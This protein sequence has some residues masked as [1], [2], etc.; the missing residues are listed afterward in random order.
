M[1][2]KLSLCNCSYSFKNFRDVSD[3]VSSLSRLW[4]EM[5]VFFQNY[6]N[7]MELLMT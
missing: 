6:F 1:L 2:F 7:V 3:S 5:K 4:K